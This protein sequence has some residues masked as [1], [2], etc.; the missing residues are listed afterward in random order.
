M[1]AVGAT[2]ILVLIGDAGSNANY[3]LY[4]NWPTT[5]GPDLS[6]MPCLQDLMNQGEQ[7]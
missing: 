5:E 1:K 4:R 2:A 6:N 3:T 7:P